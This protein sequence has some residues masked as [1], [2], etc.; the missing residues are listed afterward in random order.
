MKKKNTL[1]ELAIKTKGCQIHL[2]SLRCV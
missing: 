1:A 2:S